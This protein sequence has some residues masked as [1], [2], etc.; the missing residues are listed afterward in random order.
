MSIAAR[1]PSGVRWSGQL[2]ATILLCLVAAYFVVRDGLP[3]VL[4]AVQPS[5]DPAAVDTTTPLLA[6]YNAAHDTN[7]RRIEGR[8]MFFPPPDWKR[9]A[10][11]PPPPAPPPPPPPPPQPPESYTGK[12]PIGILGNTVFFEGGSTID[13]GKESDGIKVVEILS[14]WKV[15]LNHL[16][17]DY[18]VTLGTKPDENLFKPASARTSV[19][20]IVT[21]SAAA[22]TPGAST[23]APAGSTATG[24]AAPAASRAGAAPAPAPATAG[25]AGIPP[26]LTEEGVKKMTTEEAQAAMQ[27]IRV[28]LESP[29][30]DDETRTRLSAE[31]EWLSVRMRNQ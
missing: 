29:D 12:K 17:K 22:A 10:P 14:S 11:P 25:P 20:G 1:L 8:A 16:K 26:A 9:K 2:I 28:A 21:G 24:A 19:P 6:K 30:L 31:V 15:K 18:E 3:V 13:L 27:R 7:R 5:A 4:A 23:T